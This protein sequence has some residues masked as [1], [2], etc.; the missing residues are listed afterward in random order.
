MQD[1]DWWSIR[2]FPGVILILFDFF[3]FSEAILEEVNGAEID[4]RHTG[5]HERLTS[6]DY[7]RHMLGFYVSEINFMWFIM[8]N[9]L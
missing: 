2:R 8:F 5:Y 1:W 3:Q 6:E 4:Y 9:F 7:L